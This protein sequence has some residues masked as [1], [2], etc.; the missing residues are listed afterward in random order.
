[1][2]DDELL[3]KLYSKYESKMDYDTFLGKVG[4][5]PEVKEGY[6]KYQTFTSPAFP[7]TQDPEARK[8]VTREE[9]AEDV[10][11]LAG[12]GS[13]VLQGAS[14]NQSDE[15]MGKVAAA[16]QRVTP[17]AIGGAPAG[18]SFDELYQK[19]VS[20]LREFDANFAEE[21][22][23]ATLVGEIGGSLLG[24]G[25]V[26]GKALVK[27]AQLAQNLGKTGRAATNLA[28]GSGVGAVEGG[29]YAA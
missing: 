1:M 9:M 19:N 17:E 25:L 3:P 21:N 18:T 7:Y 2:S 14:F 5:A 11:T 29:L 4:G 20:N 24:G 12:F 27:G 6:D 15:L 26:A 28:V 10:R 23:E 13:S 8:P 22:P 16:Y